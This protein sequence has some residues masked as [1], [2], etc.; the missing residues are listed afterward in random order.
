MS[1]SRGTFILAKTYHQVLDPEYLRY[2]FATKLGTGVGDIDL[3]LDDFLQRVNSDVV[4]KFINIG[5][6]T[7][8]FINKD[9]NNKLS[10][11]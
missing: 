5:S 3:N 6:R 9:F 7:A 10:S 4:G 1:K 8:N 11:N 2:Y